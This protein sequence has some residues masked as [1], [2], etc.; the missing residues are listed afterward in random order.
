MRRK[1]R[2]RGQTAAQWTAENPILGLNEP[3]YETDTQNLKI[4]DG[5]TV[6]SALDYF[7]GSGSSGS[8]TELLPVISQ[9]NTPPGSPASG[10]RY[11]CG[12]APTGAWAGHANDIAEYDGSWTFTD[13]V[14]N[15]TVYI[16][17]S[18]TTKR[19]N[20]TSWVAYAGTAILQNGNTLGAPVS[21]GTRDN[22][23]TYFKTN[24]TN[25]VRVH[26][27]G[28]NITGNLYVGNL[29]ATANTSAIVEFTSTSKGALLPRMTTAQRNAIS[30]PATSLLIFNTS[31]GLF[32]YYDGSTWQ[33]IDSTVTSEW[34]LNGNTVGSLKY[35]GTVDNYSLPFITNN[36]ERMRIHSTGE[37]GIG[38]TSTPTSKLQVR[39]SG[40][41]SSTIAL[42][43]QNST[44][45]NIL[46]VNDGRQVLIN[47]GGGDGE[48]FGVA[49]VS[50]N[51]R[52]FVVYNNGYNRLL[53]VYDDGT[54]SATGSYVH[55][56]NVGTGSQFY[57]VANAWY[58]QPAT[59][60]YY[61]INITGTPVSS[62]L[63]I[64]SRG[65]GGGIDFYTDA[66]HYFK[67]RFTETSGASSNHI[68]SSDG[69]SYF[70]SVSTSQLGVGT[71]APHASSKLEVTS[72][73]M[74]FRLTPMT[75]TQ[76]SAIT[77]A[78]GL[79]VCVSDTNGTFTSIGYWA[80][81]NGA[82]AKH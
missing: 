3:G 9:T 41:T 79:M 16:T 30:T 57:H 4:G 31:L 35:F 65:T 37:I 40:A 45:S 52:I 43:I 69:I 47:G 6:W 33:Q 15:N 77:P 12:T 5:T 2:F 18:L 13:P 42:L 76:A 59:N 17:A 55:F 44:P 70:A 23:V 25:R 74:G 82:W 20:G 27:S 11:L 54:G 1:Q 14:L 58:L 22:Q 8:I 78:E 51:S 80:Y 19:F 63:M 46:E 36:T 28:M 39:G 56:G 67:I 73:T 24:N 72:T 38:F 61:A 68:I 34:Q 60:P 32:E 50:V 66:S 21:I 29:T 81:E 7:S 49:K 10:D 48:V 62:N 71:S 75:A 53:G 26:N 64:F